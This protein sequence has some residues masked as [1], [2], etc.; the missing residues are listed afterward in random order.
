MIAD[1]KRIYNEGMDAIR[2]LEI[3]VRKQESAKHLTQMRQSRSSKRAS[4]NSSRRAWW[5]TCKNIESIYPSETSHGWGGKRISKMR[6]RKW[7]NRMKS[8][9][10]NPDLEL[11]WWRLMDLESWRILD[12]PC[13]ISRLQKWQ[14][15]TLWRSWLI[16]MHISQK[17]CTAYRETMLNWSPC[18]DCASQPKRGLSVWKNPIGTRKGTVGRMASRLACITTVEIAAA[19]KM[20][21]K[22]GKQGKYYVRKDVELKLDL[23]KQVTDKTSGVSRYFNK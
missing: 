14:R 18:W 7:R 11:T 6:L 16:P 9:P 10:S 4:I 2:K 23:Q 8:R 13:R 22:R 19:H 5:K 17:Q 3:Y 1:N 20:D 21:I 15:M 12:I